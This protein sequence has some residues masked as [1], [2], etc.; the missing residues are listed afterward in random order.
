MFIFENSPEVNNLIQKA[1]ELINAGQNEQA[2][3]ILDN[4]M[5]GGKISMQMIPADNFQYQMPGQGQMW[6]R[7][8]IE[9]WYLF[10]SVCV[11]SHITLKIKN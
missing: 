3:D 1:S 11:L 9:L 6:M 4:L 2:N 7:Q 10:V 8:Q 5:Q